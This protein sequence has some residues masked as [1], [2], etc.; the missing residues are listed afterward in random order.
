M[1]DEAE[2]DVVLRRVWPKCRNR[3]QEWQ[4]M[5]VID[6]TAP[7]EYVT[8]PQSKSGT[9]NLIVSFLVELPNAEEENHP[10]RHP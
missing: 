4:A 6:F 5:I 7:D 10:Q 8:H 2:Q 9:R 1:L 3:D